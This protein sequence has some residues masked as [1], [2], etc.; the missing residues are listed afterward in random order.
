[1]YNSEIYYDLEKRLKDWLNAV[2]GEVSNLPLDLLNRAQNKLTMHRLW[3]DMLR[4]TEL[5][6]VSGESKTYQFPTD[7]AA[8][9]YLGA[10]VDGNGKDDT[11]YYAEARNYNGYRL[12]DQFTK[13]AGHSWVAEFYT[14]PPFTPRLTY[15]KRLEDFVGYDTAAEHSANPQYTFFPGELLMKCAQVIHIEETGLTSSEV[16]VL[17]NSYNQ[18]LDDY[19][20]AHQ[21]VN[22]ELTMELKDSEGHIINNES[23][24][25]GG[26]FGDNSFTRGF[27]NDVDL[28]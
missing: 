24:D 23:L 26:N 22:T 20:T 1:M 28:V 6:L 17:V 9:K 11:W 15:Q 18:L 25:L 7:V 8:Y 10:D 12:E 27:E 5:S 16:Q 4:V 2:G 14:A 21:N 19:T 13:A 3:S